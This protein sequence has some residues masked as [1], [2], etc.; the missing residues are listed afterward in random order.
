MRTES[1]QKTYHLI[2]AQE[3]LPYLQPKPRDIC[4]RLILL[5]KKAAPQLKLE[6]KFLLIKIF[7]LTILVSKKV[8]LKLNKLNQKSHKINKK[9]IKH[10]KYFKI[11]NYRFKILTF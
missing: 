10:K 7:L 2:T 6:V 8:L 4:L 9:I 1:N 11:N 3:K 5:P